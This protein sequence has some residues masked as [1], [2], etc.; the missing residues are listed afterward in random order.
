MFPIMI[1]RWI[2]FRVQFLSKQWFFYSGI[3]TFLYTTSTK[4]RFNIILDL[5]EKTNFW[6]KSAKIYFTSR[7]TKKNRELKV[8][9]KIVVRDSAKVDYNIYF[10]AVP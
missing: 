5:R 3:R 2:T 4:F 10:G 1:V 9:L 8:C 7:D 6:S